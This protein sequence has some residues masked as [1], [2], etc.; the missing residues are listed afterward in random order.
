[1]PAIGAGYSAAATAKAGSI[2]KFREKNSISFQYIGG[3]ADGVESKPRDFFYGI[4][5]LC[6]EIVIKTCFQIFNYTMFFSV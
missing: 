1:M 3:I 4:K 2:I 5:A 6:M